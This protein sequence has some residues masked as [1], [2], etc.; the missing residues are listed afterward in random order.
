MSVPRTCAHEGWGRY[1]G[2]DGPCP[3]PAEMNGCAH[4]AECPTCG[5][6]I[7]FVQSCTC[8][9]ASQTYEAAMVGGYEVR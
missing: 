3:P 6:R 8:A 9:R 7:T 5:Y 4:C 1:E 2:E